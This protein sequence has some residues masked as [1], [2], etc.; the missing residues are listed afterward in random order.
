MMKQSTR[1]RA[2][3]CTHLVNM[4]HSVRLER[5]LWAFT[6]CAQC[7]FKCLTASDGDDIDIKML[8]SPLVQTRA[9]KVGHQPAAPRSTAM[10]F[11]KLQ[12][13]QSQTYLFTLPP[14]LRDTIYRLALVRSTPSEYFK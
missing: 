3:R 5:G 7:W 6:M 9:I 11:S 8:R 12:H 2:P 4:Q 10:P 13:Q 14:E 1:S